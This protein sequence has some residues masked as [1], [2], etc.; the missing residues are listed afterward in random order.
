MKIARDEYACRDCVLES[1]SLQHG[2]PSA[3]PCIMMPTT[4]KKLGAHSFSKALLLSALAALSVAYASCQF[5]VEDDDVGDGY[6]Y[7]DDNGC[8]YCENGRCVPNES[9]PG[10]NCSTNFQCEAGCFCNSEGYCAEAGFCTY[11]VDCPPG[12][13]CDRRYSCVPEGTSAGCESDEVCPIGSYC[14]EEIGECVDSGACDEAGNCPDEQICDQVRNTCLPIDDA[15]LTCQ[16]PVSCEEVAPICP[17]GSTPAIMK[18]C[19]TGTCMDKD[20][21]PDGAPF[22]CSDLND[23]ESACLENAS[24]GAVYKGIN[25]TSPRGDICTSGEAECTCESFAF[26]YCEES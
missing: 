5:Y 18:G 3:S 20:N 16:S 19:Y 11:D 7:C 23:D 4:R 13:E 14:D 9:Q 1:L 15:G 8:Y 22:A 26:D 21:C 12:F 10:W 17:A 25:C 2:T 24:C 6:S